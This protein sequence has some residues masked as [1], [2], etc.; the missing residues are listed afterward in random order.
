MKDG[1]SKINKIEDFITYSRDLSICINLNIL[2][3]LVLPFRLGFFSTYWAGPGWFKSGHVWQKCRLDRA[4]V[5][6]LNGTFFQGPST[7]VVIILC[8]HKCSA[9][10]LQMTI[11]YIQEFFFVFFQIYHIIICISTWQRMTTKIND[12]NKIYSTIT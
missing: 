5:M 7:W 1:W 2:S 8:N 4:F 6:L 10:C 12:C 11:H 3:Y 9:M